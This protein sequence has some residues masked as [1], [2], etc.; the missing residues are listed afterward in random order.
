LFSVKEMVK[1][2]RKVQVWKSNLVKARISKL[3]DNNKKEEFTYNVKNV[4][5]L[6]DDNNLSNEEYLGPIKKRVKKEGKGSKAF[7]VA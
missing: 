1:I 3:S 4:Q 6:N 2:T 5:D 7:D